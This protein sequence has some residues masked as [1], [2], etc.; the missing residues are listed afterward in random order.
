MDPNEYHST[1]RA[2]GSS[3]EKVS[4][5]TQLWRRE[6]NGPHLSQ[7]KAQTSL[8]VVQIN[9]Q[10]CKAASGILAKRMEGKTAMIVLAQEPWVIGTKICGKIPEANIHVGDGLRSK[11]RACIY[12]RGIEAW[13]LTEFSSKDLVAV[14]VPR[15]NDSD[16]GLAIASVYMA[17][18]DPAPSEKV[19][20]LVRHCR[21][22]NIPLIMGGDVNSHHTSWGSSDINQRGEELMEFLIEEGID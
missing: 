22:N 10:H 11:P 14:R 4:G 5:R 3:S 2:Q 19:R 7:Q 21:V 8:D 13:K 20:R 17:A 9:L 16:Q 1:E 6:G 15:T 12:T 18:E